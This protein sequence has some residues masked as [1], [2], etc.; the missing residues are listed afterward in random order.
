[1]ISAMG[2]K[3]KSRIEYLATILLG[4]A[5]VS[6]V[7]Y[8]SGV[9][10]QGAQTIS[11]ES[12]NVPDVEPASSNQAET[13]LDDDSP[14]IESSENDDSA[15]QKTPEADPDASDGS[16]SAASYFAFE[17]DS[18]NE[19]VQY[20]AN[21]EVA[22]ASLVKIATA[23]VVMEYADLDDEVTIEASDLVD[24]MVDSNMFLIEGD[25]L[26]V[27]QLLQGLL[28]PSGSDAANALARSAGAEISGESDAEAA[29]AA[30]VG[31][32][33]AYAGDLG[34]EHTH[35]TNPTGGDDPDSYSTAREIALLGAELMKNDT[36]AAI[37]AQPDY[38]FVSV[39]YE[40][41]YSGLTTNQLLGENGV[42]G[43]KTGS[44]DAAGGC[45]VFARESPGGEIQVIAILG[46][47][48]A[49]EEHIIV[50][51][52]RWQEARAL[53]RIIDADVD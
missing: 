3:T 8:F 36:L 4:V 44:T 18:E 24:P 51:D 30:F 26:T 45:V 2:R 19:L 52:T 25:T 13:T 34:L 35:F 32:M 39:G 53:F 41:H 31:A 38:S 46:A 23:L 15:P 10:T 5:L 9:G 21:S 1:M 50:L 40:Q 29:I 28:I 27:E 49:Y 11:I 48:L 14:P 16:A 42:I 43:I 7:A 6:L 33:N 22:I 47:D 12:P 20:A 37:V 17:L